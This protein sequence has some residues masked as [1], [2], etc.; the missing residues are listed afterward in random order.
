MELDNNKALVNRLKQ[1]RWYERHSAKKNALTEKY[2]KDNWEKVKAQTYK[3]LDPAKHKARQ[4]VN[5]A[6]AAGKFAKLPCKNCGEVKTNFHH[7]NGYDK[8]NWF[9]GEW[10][11]TKHHAQL[12]KELRWQ[13]N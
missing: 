10:L 9:T 4:A 6:V 13:T 7:N 2:R 11:C 3:R 5:N 8:D 12:H 1:R